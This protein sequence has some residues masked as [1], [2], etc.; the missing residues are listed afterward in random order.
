V[1]TLTLTSTLPAPAGRAGFG[2]AL[3]SEWTKLVSLRSTVWT[4][5]ATMA[6][7]I[8]ISTLVSW[9]ASNRIH[10]LMTDNRPRG[11]R[12]NPATFDSVAASMYGLIF[13]QLVIA[14]I[15][16]MAI[17]SEYG[18]GMIRTSLTAQPRRLVT[19]GAKLT[20]FTVVAAVTGL[21]SSFASFFIGQHNYAKVALNVGIGGPNALRAV[22]GGA[23]F[24][25]AAGLLAFGL[26]AILRHTAGAISAA[27]GILFV[28]FI[29]YQ[30]LPDNWAA[31]VQRFLPFF[32][33]SAIWSA[34]PDPDTAGHLWGPWVEFGV[35]TGY[36]VLALVV[37]TIM[38]RR[39]DA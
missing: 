30:F 12:F 7:T 13:G 35:F 6:V 8:G 26:G 36:A 31:D 32:A 38:F 27:V 11:E 20:V 19:L 10:E 21:I 18:T 17:T 5:V 2:G 29:L 22:I 28:S 4:L 33:G 37:G 16:A 34:K 14:V 9:G 1:T 25:T 15:G 23:L 24:L 39:R 3:R